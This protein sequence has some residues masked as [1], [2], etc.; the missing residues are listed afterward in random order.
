M[1]NIIHFNSEWFI[2]VAIW[3]K[4][5]HLNFPHSGWIFTLK[6]ISKNLLTSFFLEHKTI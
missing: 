5:V 3:C 2:V 4:E 6:R 1:F